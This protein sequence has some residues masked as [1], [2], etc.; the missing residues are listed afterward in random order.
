MRASQVEDSGQCALVSASPDRRLCALGTRG[1]GQA[2]D[3]SPPGFRTRRGNNAPEEMHHRV[4]IGLAASRGLLG[5][6]GRVTPERPLAPLLFVSPK[7]FANLIH[8]SRVLL[9]P[10]EPECA[11][12]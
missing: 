3:I 1:R 12:P 2:Q 11:L 8:E 9:F 6:G 4:F 5:R 7:E 10:P